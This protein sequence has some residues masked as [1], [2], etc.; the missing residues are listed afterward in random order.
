M[1]NGEVV[2][3]GEIRAAEQPEGA[4]GEVDGVVDIRARGE[5]LPVEV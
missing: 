4:C 1:T 3:A 5:Q 2:S